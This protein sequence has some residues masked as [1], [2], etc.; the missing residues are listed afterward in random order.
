MD[1]KEARHDRMA[2]ASA[3]TYVDHLHFS[4][5]NHASTSSFNFYRP[6]VLPDAQTTSTD[7]I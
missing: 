2:V 7:G 3:G 1:F 6:N 5:D 4:P